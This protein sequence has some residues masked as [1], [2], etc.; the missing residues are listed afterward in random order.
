MPVP[1][2][3]PIPP[4]INETD[5]FLTAGAD[6]FINCQNFNGT[7]GIEFQCRLTGSGDPFTNSTFIDASAPDQDMLDHG[8][9]Q[10]N[11]VRARFVVN[12]LHTALSDWCVPVPATS[13]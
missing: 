9:E 13:G 5:F 10:D 8:L 4:P 3:E 1:P 12:V 7:Y 6:G 2:P 11:D